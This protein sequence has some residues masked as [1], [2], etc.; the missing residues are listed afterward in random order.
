VIKVGALFTNR[1]SGGAISPTGHVH[2]E[3]FELDGAIPVWT[4]AISLIRI[5]ARVWLEPGANTTYAAWRLVVGPEPSS[6]LSLRVRLMINDRDHHTQTAARGIDPR[7]EG[8]ASRLRVLQPDFSLTFCASGGVI[9]AARQWI[10]NFD[11][12]VERER[13]FMTATIISRSRRLASSWSPA[14]GSALAAACTTIHPP[15][16]KLR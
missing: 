14:D 7:L 6:S 11:L 2:I 13:G 10:E 12:P 15:T 9:T 1:W 8:E 16:W 5:E 3:S 4:F